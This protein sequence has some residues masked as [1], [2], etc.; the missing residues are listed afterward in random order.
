MEFLPG[1]GGGMRIQLS[2]PDT[3]DRRTSRSALDEGGSYRVFPETRHPQV[4]SESQ[5]SGGGVKD[6]RPDRVQT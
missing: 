3:E 1:T 4:S 2:C 6:P 5:S